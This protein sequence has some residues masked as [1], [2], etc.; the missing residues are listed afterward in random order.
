MAGR[1]NRYRRGRSAT[2]SSRKTWHLYFGGLLFVLAVVLSRGSAMQN[3]EVSLFEFVYNRPE[4]L[5]FLFFVITQ[6]GSIHALG[7]V[8]IILLIRQRYDAFSKVLFGST[9]AYL[10]SGFAKDIWGRVRPHEFLGNVV[11]LDYEVRGPGFPSG[12]TALVTVLVLVL[13]NYLPSKFRYV[14]FAVIA[15]VGYS[16]MFL[17]VHAPLDVLGG[18]AIG[19]FVYALL[20]HLRIANFLSGAKDRKN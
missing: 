17:G 10:L 6:L 19:Y 1:V 9:M 16:R 4:Y 20:L 15:L 11:N 2:L 13:L 12:H 18:F 14:G 7:V 5:R 3:W 8:L